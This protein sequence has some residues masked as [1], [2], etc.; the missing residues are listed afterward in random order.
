VPAENTY[1]A[2]VERGAE[3]DRR[4]IQ[5]LDVVHYEHVSVRSFDETVAVLERLV[6]SI[7]HGFDKEVQ[8]A[9]DEADFVSR[10]QAREGSSGFMRF[11]T[12]N[13]GAW[14][15]RVGIDA[16]SILYILG[17]PLIARTML[18]HHLGA[19]LNVPVRLTI[20]EDQAGAVRVTYDLPSSLI[21]GLANEN[22]TKA[23][24][25]LDAKLVALGEQVA[26][27]VA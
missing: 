13:H 25:I 20:Y 7:E 2:A 14:L 27:V 23:A 4:V 19:G 15:R 9:E 12:I 5:Q 3:G 18:V 10:I 1:W 24:K 26:G 8:G 17:N 6:G 11:Q 22:V 16:R 21:G